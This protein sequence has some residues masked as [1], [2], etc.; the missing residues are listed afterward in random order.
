MLNKDIANLIFE[1]YILLENK[2]N[3]RAAFPEFADKINNLDN[4]KALWLYSRFVKRSVKE[5]HPI[6]DCFETLD[7][8]VSI[9]NSIKAKFQRDANFV[10]IVNK[11]L[12][13]KSWDT[14]NDI[15]KLTID[16]MEMLI[17]L[18]ERK[19]PPFNIDAV[20]ITDEEFVGKVDEWNIYVPFTRES[21]CVIAQYDSMTYIPKT[22]WCTARIHGSNLFYN[23][24]GREN[25]NII[26]YYLIKDNPVDVEDY[27]SIGI[28]DNEIILEGRDGG[29]SVDRDN[30]GLTEDRVEDILGGVTWKKISTEIKENAKK[31][32][33]EKG[34]L[35]HPA[36]QK[37]KKARKDVNEFNDAIRGLSAT[38]TKD[39]VDMV[40]GAG[41]NDTVVDDVKMAIF[42]NKKYMQQSFNERFKMH[43]NPNEKS[44]LTFDRDFF[45]TIRKIFSGGQDIGY[46]SGLTESNINDEKGMYTKVVSKFILNVLD[47]MIKARDEDLF[48]LYRVKDLFNAE[49]AKI[50]MRD[51]ERHLYKPLNR[52]I[53]NLYAAEYLENLKR[54]NITAHIDDLISVS[55]SKD[56]SDLGITTIPI[57]STT[58]DHHGGSLYSRYKHLRHKLATAEQLD[59]IEAYGLQK[60]SPQYQTGPTSIIWMKYS[61][62]AFVFR[63]GQK[64]EH[65]FNSSI[66]SDIDRYNEYKKIDETKTLPTPGGKMPSTLLQQNFSTNFNWNSD[67]KSKKK[68]VL[69][70]HGQLMIKVPTV[71][72]SFYL[73]DFIDIL[74]GTRVNSSD[75]AGN[76]LVASVVKEGLYDVYIEKIKTLI[77][78]INE[79]LYAII[80]DQNIEVVCLPVTANPLIHE[81]HPSRR[82]SWKETGKG[83]NCP[84]VNL[85]NPTLEAAKGKNIKQAFMIAENAHEAFNASL[86]YNPAST[87]VANLNSTALSIKND[88]LDYGQKIKVFD[89]FFNK[90]AKKE[91]LYHPGYAWKGRNKIDNFLLEIGKA[92][93]VNFKSQISKIDY[94]GARSFS[95]RN[96][97]TKRFSAGQGSSIARLFQ[98]TNNIS[99]SFGNEVGSV[100]FNAFDTRK[101]IDQQ[102]RTMFFN[103]IVE[104]MKYFNEL[105]ELLNI[106][107]GHNFS[108]VGEAY[109]QRSLNKEKMSE[110]DLTESLHENPM[111]YLSSKIKPV[112]NHFTFVTTVESYVMN[113]LFNIDKFVNDYNNIMIKSD[114]SAEDESDATEQL[115]MLYDNMHTVFKYI[116][117]I[118]R[119]YIVDVV[120]SLLVEVFGSNNFISSPN[121]F[122]SAAEKSEQL[123]NK[124][125][126]KNAK[127]FYR[128]II[129]NYFFGVMGSVIFQMEMAIEHNYPLTDSRI[130][131]ARK[132]IYGGLTVSNAHKL[133]K[134]YK[135]FAQRENVSTFFDLDTHKPF[136][137]SRFLS[138]LFDKAKTVAEFNSCVDIFDE[139]LDVV[140]IKNKKNHGFILSSKMF[141]SW[142]DMTEY[143]SAMKNSR[144]YKTI[145]NAHSLKK[146]SKE[147]YFIIMSLLNKMDDVAGDKQH[148]FLNSAVGVA[149]NLGIKDIHVDNHSI[150]EMAIKNLMIKLK[151]TK[152]SIF[153]TNMPQSI[154]V[155]NLFSSILPTVYTAHVYKLW[156]ELH[157]ELSK[158]VYG[159][160][161]FNEIKG[162]SLEGFDS[163]N[164]SEKLRIV[165]KMHGKLIRDSHNEVQENPE[166]TAADGAAGRPGDIFKDTLFRNVAKVYNERANVTFSNH[167]AF[168]KNHMLSGKLDKNYYEMLNKI[169]YVCW[170]TCE[171]YSVG[172]FDISESSTVNLISTLAKV[173]HVDTDIDKYN[174]MLKYIYPGGVDSMYEVHILDMPFEHFM[175]CLLKKYFEQQH[176]SDNITS[177]MTPENGKQ[178]LEQ[179]KKFGFD[180]GNERKMSTNRTH[181][182]Q[183]SL[184]LQIFTNEFLRR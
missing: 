6:E 73:S 63:M 136:L 134:F 106:E 115:K 91:I 17:I 40:L 56:I 132:T 48:E 113:G 137:Y 100:V 142:N 8:Y 16:E 89:H 117:D 54:M 179:V 125:Q 35:V 110:N 173:L 47:G 12:P 143:Q 126:N 184:L 27:L 66:Q 133:I 80:R 118:T 162:L 129:E 112:R 123:Y 51:T 119:I 107:I 154:R 32:K 139:Y 155:I 96:K 61:D 148:M 28:R 102:M 120:K 21:S 108:N 135:K 131:I 181:A 101:K 178:F 167:G 121:D 165:G 42:E 130:E 85:K 166:F 36:K 183:V 105:C 88:E 18:R 104:H 5:V 157:N 175:L 176:F 111:L 23:Y 156:K 74:T 152:P 77:S 72:D 99:E 138:E 9:E 4:R 31:W 11:T 30:N 158:Q 169:L 127:N 145:I 83:F 97:V 86:G 7:N 10:A 50:G 160:G 52:A 122:L 79:R 94:I 60:F 84:P 3:L 49:N 65:R 44:H 45:T 75:Y 182:D 161:V 149:G 171:N 53:H 76:S 168:I 164:D 159:T 29:L 43:V 33:D 82:M 98:N 144:R 19:Q 95:E 26:L 15:M 1:R 163:D 38:E 81:Y 140:N 78:K 69:F 90:F 150:C 172:Y 41:K 180:H 39:I 67:T 124:L 116:D 46:Y 147:K 174:N 20:Q 22:T 70:L 13:D 64:T 71:G 114:G 37:V 141:E 57:R 58:A 25:H 55:R 146:E 24:V 68:K 14:P 153:S 59:F 2:K 109:A 92:N 177:K 93:A 170:E 103:K 34:N 62:D 151:N 128:E 87:N